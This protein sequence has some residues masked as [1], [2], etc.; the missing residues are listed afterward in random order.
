MGEVP[1]GIF[2]ALRFVDAVFE[3]LS[4]KGELDQEGVVRAAEDLI[5]FDC[6]GTGEVAADFGMEVRVDA[7]RGR[8]LGPLILPPHVTATFRPR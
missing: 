4:V 1:E 6:G 2:A 3:G 7:R 5:A 8:E